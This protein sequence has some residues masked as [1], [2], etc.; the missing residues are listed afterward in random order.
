M[1]ILLRTG[2]VSIFVILMSLVSCTNDVCY[3]CIGFEGNTSGVLQDTVICADQF[4]SRKAF[5]DS[6][7][8]YEQLG[9]TCNEQ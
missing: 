1:N 8:I 9:G 5:D 6:V 4:S 7:E 3:E 2:L